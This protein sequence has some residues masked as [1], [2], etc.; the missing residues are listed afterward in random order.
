MMCWT[1]EE[2]MIAAAADVIKDH[3]IALVGIGLPNL[4]AMLAKQTH[5]PNLKLVYESGAIDASPE[6]LPQRTWRFS[7]I[8]HIRNEHVIV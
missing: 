8:T 4:A 2:L 5:A 3:D 1:K 7:V 6:N